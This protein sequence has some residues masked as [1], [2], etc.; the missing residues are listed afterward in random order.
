MLTCF[1]LWG[2]KR[3]ISSAELDQKI[4][5]YIAQYQ[6]LAMSESQRSGIPASI[7]LA[8][9]IL[10]SRYGESDLAVKA[11]NHFGIKCKLDWTG[12]K[13]TA[14][15]DTPTDCFRKYPSSDASYIDHTDFLKNHRLNFYDHLFE[16]DKR[17]YKA[18]A[19]GLQLVGYATT[20]YYAKS[21]ILLIEKYELYFFDDSEKG[22]STPKE[23]I[24]GLSA[25]AQKV[26]NTRK[27][28]PKKQAIAA[29]TKK[30][31]PV[32]QKPQVKQVPVVPKEVVSRVHIVKEGEIM[33]TIAALHKLDV[34]KL[35]DYNQLIF[36]SQPET[37]TKL[38]L[39]KKALTSPK[40]RVIEYEE[41]KHI[42]T[43]NYGLF[44]TSNPLLQEVLNYALNQTIKARESS[45]TA[46]TADI[47]SVA[48]L[49]NGDL[50][51]QETS[52]P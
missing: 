43:Q 38:Y 7:K 40:L 6:Y 41:V 10:E 24:T 51:S 1:S 14:H 12:E 26:F 13:V 18:W 4:F 27:P 20:D 37:G 36:G 45:V 8:Q 11:N 39:D 48:P 35:Y 29:H 3:Q 23:A 52:I 49:L 30:N 5:D 22:W 44:D 17:D 46:H 28:T 32:A 33:E 2:Q 42:P 47:N 19:K 15:D 9:G 34:E 25:K 16:I 31:I 50:S 21:L